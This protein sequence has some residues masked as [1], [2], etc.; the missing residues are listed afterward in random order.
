MAFY[1]TFDKSTSLPTFY[2]QVQQKDAHQELYNFLSLGCSGRCRE[3]SKKLYLAMQR[4]KQIKLMRRRVIK[5]MR[6]IGLDKGFATKIALLLE[7]SGL[8]LAEQKAIMKEI[9]R[10][11]LDFQRDMFN[12]LDLGRLKL[13]RLPISLQR[14]IIALLVL[15]AEIAHLFRL[16]LERQRVNREMN[17]LSRISM[18]SRDFD[19]EIVDLN[20]DYH[21]LSRMGV[22][23]SKGDYQGNRNYAYEDSMTSDFQEEK[24]MYFDVDTNE[25]T[26][27]Q[28]SEQNQDQ[29]YYRTQQDFSQT[30]DW[31]AEDFYNA[32][33]EKKQK[34][35]VH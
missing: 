4:K 22:A 3:L 2:S 21:K 24:P 34:K 32:K 5:I 35:I 23:L 16:E 13:S 31:S 25:D 7:R 30:Y 6:K 29:Q 15:K 20:T 26:R 12:N 17:N 19:R 28:A 14:F 8:S 10:L 9:K 27:N 33:Q 18:D 1:F 11:L